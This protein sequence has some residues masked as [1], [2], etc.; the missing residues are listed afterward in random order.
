MTRL[1][2]HPAYATRPSNVDIPDTEIKA[3][4]T[5][6]ARFTETIARHNEQSAQLAATRAALREATAKNK[7]AVR[8]AARGGK[9]IE[10]KKLVKRARDL[11]DT[12]AELELELEAAD[13]IANSQHAA[14]VG[15]LLH[16]APALK[17]EA[18]AGLDADMLRL[19]T[20]HAK[21]RQLRTG[22]AERLGVLGL[23][24]RLQRGDSPVM[25]TPRA[26]AGTIIALDTAINELAAAVTGVSLAIEAGK[27]PAEAP[28]DTPDDDT[29]DDDSE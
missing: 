24:E 19:A 20:E 1:S 3:I 28:D 5:E 11:E 12:A 23:L 16:N 22:V 15:V 9:P 21:V 17:A 27:R 7:E 13:A 6:A 26:H 4:T 29:P 14:L 10:S 8:I 2:F 25:N 18:L